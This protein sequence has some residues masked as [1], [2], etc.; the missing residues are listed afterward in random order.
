MKKLIAFIDDDNGPIVYYVMALEDAG[1]EVL[2]L[3]TFTEALD[4][5]TS[6]SRRPDFWIVDLMM[7]IEDAALRVDGIPVIETTNMGL[8]AGLLLYRKIKE[9]SLNSP[10]IV[11]T[12][13][14]TPQILDQIE[15][16]LEAGDTCE[17][18]LDLLPHELALK[19]RSR[20]L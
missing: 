15:N 7:A 8:A 12:S 14:P 9:S 3:H 5:I 4:F 6:S 20:I 10:S 16:S 2:R 18:K 11:L 1:F 17:A 19:V 13:I